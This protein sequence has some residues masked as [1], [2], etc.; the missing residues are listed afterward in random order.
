MNNI[1]LKNEVDD[2]R[3]LVKD[4]CPE[5]LNIVTVDYVKDTA[6]LFDKSAMDIV[7]E[8]RE[9]IRINTL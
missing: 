4:S 7:N 1:D 6:D 2:L 9:E 5:M 3:V 8:I